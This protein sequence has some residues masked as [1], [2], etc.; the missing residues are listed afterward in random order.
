VGGQ[1]FGSGARQAAS[2]G[3]RARVPLSLSEVAHPQPVVVYHISVWLTHNTSLMADHRRQ[4]AS[5][6]SFVD[7]LACLAQAFSV[8][9]P[10][11]CDARAQANEQAS[12][13]VIAS[14]SRKARHGTAYPQ[15]PRTPHR[16]APLAALQVMR[17]IHTPAP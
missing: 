10:M 6:Y 9:I 4:A 15:G 17:G 13:C 8:L 16:T 14:M 5:R 3:A 7:A 11:H 1:A 2:A 12:L